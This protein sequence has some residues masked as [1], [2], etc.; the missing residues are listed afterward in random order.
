MKKG[1][2]LVCLFLVTAYFVKAQDTLLLYYNGSWGK[3]DKANS[4][5]IRK[6]YLSSGFWVVQDFYTKTGSLE[7]N[8]VY[9]SIQDNIKEGAFTNYYENGNKKSEGS[10]Y[11]GFKIGNWQSWYE[12]GGIRSKESYI[13]DIEIIKKIKEEGIIS[14]GYKLNVGKYFLDS[15]SIFQGTSQWFYPNGQMSAEEE[16]ASSLVSVKH[17][18]EAGKKQKVDFDKEDPVWGG[19]IKLPIPKDGYRAAFNVEHNTATGNG[20]VIIKFTI[21]EKGVMEE[22]GISQ[23]SDNKS[24]DDKA[25]SM[26]KMAAGREWVVG[27]RHNLPSTFI[28][29]L[30]ISFNKDSK[31]EWGD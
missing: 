4:T 14:L 9:K 28:C 24:L 3:T 18:S 1:S 13:N 15:L 27:R 8:G 31:W 23:S 10:F 22:I 20:K 2:F 11:D 26:S 19:V 12:D 6:A 25:I 30:P 7:K 29:L 17:W 16:W 5:F 21:N